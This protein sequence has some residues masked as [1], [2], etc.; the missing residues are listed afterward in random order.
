MCDG[1]WWAVIGL[2]SRFGFSLDLL[3]VR[4][5]SLDFWF[6]ASKDEQTDELWLGSFVAVILVFKVT[7]VQVT[8]PQQLRPLQ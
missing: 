5:E 6:S 2:I 7:Q 8:V 3:L 1:L 4:V